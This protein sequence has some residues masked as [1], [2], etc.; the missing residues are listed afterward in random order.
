MKMQF[1]HGALLLLDV[2]W[3]N[4]STLLTSQG[5]VVYIYI[6]IYIYS[7]KIMFWVSNVG[8]NTLHKPDG[9]QILNGMQVRYQCEAI[10]LYH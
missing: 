5:E 6:Y 3:F 2:I 4:W 8:V 7:P 9:N 10:L 1:S